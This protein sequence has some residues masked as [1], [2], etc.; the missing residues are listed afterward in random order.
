MKKKGKFTVKG[1]EK[2]A[3]GARPELA[4]RKM[5][6]N[7]TFKMG[8][9]IGE[10][11][12]R[13]ETANERAAARQ[14]DKNRQIRRLVFTIISFLVLMVALV[15]LGFFF[16]GDGKPAPAAKPTEPVTAEPTVEIIDEDAASGEHIT[17]RMKSYIGQAEQDFHD[18]GYSS[19]KVVIPAGSIREVDFYLSGYSGFIKMHI[20]R[21]TAVSVEDTDRM[22]RYLASQGIN[23][24]QYIDVRIG[25]KA[26]WK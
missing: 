3:N 14:K 22:L 17:N 24:F 1:E 19:A 6:R 12:E 25:G 4:H 7:S 20:D 15:F 2:D 23:E 26:Y 5:N 13:L 9:T 21:D 10:K 18:L 11:R 8:R 16:I